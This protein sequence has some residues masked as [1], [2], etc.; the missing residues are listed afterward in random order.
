MIASSFNHTPG[1]PV[2]KSKNLVDWKLFDYVFDK[3]PF[4]RFE[5]VNHGDGAWAPSLRYHKGIF[6]AVI[7]FPDEGIYV[8]STNDIEKEN[9]SEP[10]CLIEGKGIIDPCP[11][12]YDD[13]CY[14]AV[15]F[16]KSRTGFN[17]VIGLYEVSCDLKVNIS[18]DY[19]IIYDGHNDNPTIEG[20]KF[21][22]RNN[23]FYLMCP[24]GSVKTGWQTCLRS[25]NIYGPYESKIVM[26]Q[27]DSNING[28]HQG[29]LVPI[30]KTHDA[31]IHF[32]D[33]GVYGRVINLQPVTWCNDWPIC[34]TVKDE[35]LAG[36]PVSEEDYL[37][38]LKS[39][40]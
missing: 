40:C 33:M 23:Y 21:Y 11:I 15:A 30:D 8:S 32:Q 20:P 29:A 4:K 25:K 28:P 38:D 18:N 10:W 13:K 37:I 12:W 16:A 3:I 26:C 27:N 31:F 19:K 17:S 34:G 5:N 35:L 9:W 36:S 1:I 14:L 2:L 24:A 7:P 22:Y 6:Y 39:N